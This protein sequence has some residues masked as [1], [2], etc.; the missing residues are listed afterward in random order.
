[1]TCDKGFCVWIIKEYDDYDDGIYIKC[2]CV[3][4]G[5]IARGIVYEEKDKL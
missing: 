3:Q 1:M 4:C 2:T 5:K